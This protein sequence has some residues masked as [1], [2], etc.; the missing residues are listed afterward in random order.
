MLA[1]RRLAFEGPYDA[2]VDR[3]CAGVDVRSD[4]LP[5][6]ELPRL[7]CVGSPR[8]K[9]TP[10]EERK[11]QRGHESH[12][13]SSMSAAACRY[14][15]NTVPSNFLSL[16]PTSCFSLPHTGLS[17]ILIC[18]FKYYGCLPCT[19]RTHIHVSICARLQ[20][21]AARRQASLKSRSS[22]LYQDWTFQ[23]TL[24]P[25][26]Q[27]VVGDSTWAGACPAEQW[28]PQQ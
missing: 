14:E 27:R 5:V 22:A 16:Y 9:F 11:Q 10:R 13:S 6:R 28:W 20:E 23:P 4:S 12:S 21:D 2:I 24:S 26:S 19:T 18:R 7:V 1:F 17:T 8:E 25:A 3:L 15:S